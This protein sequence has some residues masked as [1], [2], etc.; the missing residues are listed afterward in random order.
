MCW[1]WIVAGCARGCS[2]DAQ[3]EGNDTNTHIHPPTHI[4]PC[5]DL[6]ITVYSISYLCKQAATT[7]TVGTKFN[8]IVKFLYLLVWQ[9]LW[10]HIDPFV[11]RGPWR[12][13][14]TH[15]RLMTA[16][17]THVCQRVVTYESNFWRHLSTM[18]LFRVL[19]W[20]F[21]VV[22]RLNNREWREL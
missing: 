20:R 15:T 2:T 5:Y 18:L 13:Q 4:G 11:A 3:I 12:G 22:E 14:S 1:R 16:R 21:Y 9:Q 6:S 19:C 7:V 10:K 8:N 17:M